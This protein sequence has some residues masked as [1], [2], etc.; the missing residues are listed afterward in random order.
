MSEEEAASVVC[1]YAN[2]CDQAGGWSDA[3]LH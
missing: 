1:L 2:K 3:E